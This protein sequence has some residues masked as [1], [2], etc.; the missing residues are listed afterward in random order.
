MYTYEIPL[1]KCKFHV[2]QTYTNKKFFLK[3]NRYLQFKKS[4][5]QMYEFHF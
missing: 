1:D 3:Y 4:K 2:L 5:A